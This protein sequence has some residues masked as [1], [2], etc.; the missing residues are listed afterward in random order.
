MIISFRTRQFVIASLIVG[1][2]LAVVMAVGWSRVLEVEVDRLDTRLCMEARRI[3]TQAF[4]GD[5]QPGLE[6][7]IA[8]KLRLGSTAQ[9]MM[10]F[11]P[12]GQSFDVSPIRWRGPSLADDLK[13][14]PERRGTTLGRSRTEPSPP[15]PAPAPGP[16]PPPPEGSLDEPQQSGSC[17]S[18][19]FT[20]AASDWRAAR[21]EAESGTSVVAADLASVKAELQ[22][23]VQSALTI[24]VPLALGLT[25]FGAWLLATLSLRPVNRLRG[26]MKGVTQQALDRRLPS[27]GEDREF[28]GLIADYNTMLARLEA[29]F[30]QASRFSADAAHEL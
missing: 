21:F 14:A 28:Q 26:A 3:A 13:W 18:T 16:R 22:G 17:S 29:S 30:R 4:R 19:S 10:R 25:A 12:R 24:V 7:D 2:V 15:R 8:L 27:N 5:D 1:T 20:S 11:D 23:A 9:L 6:A